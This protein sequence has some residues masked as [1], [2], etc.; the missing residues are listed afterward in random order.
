MEKE[1]KMAYNLI[2]TFLRWWRDLPEFHRPELGWTEF[3]TTTVIT[4]PGLW[5]IRCLRDAGGRSL[6]RCSGDE[7]SVAAAIERAKSA[8]V[9]D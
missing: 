5:G 7:N 3:E 2:R 4:R 1:K 8:G 6:R 9:L